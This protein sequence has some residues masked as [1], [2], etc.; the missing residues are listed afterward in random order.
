ML[1]TECGDV[2]ISQMVL[3]FMAAWGVGEHLSLGVVWKAESPKKSS[4]GA[5]S[6]YA[7]QLKRTRH[8]GNAST[9]G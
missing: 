4:G 8:F 5:I 1:V 6:E 3:I 9:K 2:Y 7:T